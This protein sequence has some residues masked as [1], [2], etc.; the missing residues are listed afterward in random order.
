MADIWN[1]FDTNN[2]VYK[3]MA[4]RSNYNKKQIRNTVLVSATPGKW[5]NSNSQNFVEQ[6]IRP[7][8]LIDPKIVIRPTENQIEDLLKEIFSDR[9]TIIKKILEE[10]YHK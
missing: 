5:E 2:P 3:Q 9:P 8:G 6:I 10:L 7:T 4:K 1:P